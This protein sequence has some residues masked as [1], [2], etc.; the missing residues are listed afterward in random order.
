[1]PDYTPTF[2]DLCSAIA[3]G[4][5]IATLDGSMY[6]VNAFEL[7]RYFNKP[8]TLP[9]IAALQH[10]QTREDGDSRDLQESRP[11]QRH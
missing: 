3:D 8:R 1:M 6:E 5:V 9:G 7:R 11:V 4:G 2:A 10:Q